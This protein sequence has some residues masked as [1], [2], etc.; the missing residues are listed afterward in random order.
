[1]SR[2]KQ[3]SFSNAQELHEY[4]GLMMDQFNIDEFLTYDDLYERASY[5]YM[6]LLGLR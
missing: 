3:G 1:M 6:Q 2:S 5:A 4:I